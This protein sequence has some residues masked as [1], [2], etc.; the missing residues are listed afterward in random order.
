M[1]SDTTSLLP[2]RIN[3]FDDNTQ[4]ELAAFVDLTNE[5]RKCPNQQFL[6]EEGRKDGGSVNLSFDMSLAYGYKSSSQIS[7]RLTEGWV[8]ENMYCPRCGYD[9]L[10]QFDNNR[11]VADFYCPMCNEQFELKSKGGTKLERVLDGAYHT[12]IERI[13]TNENP[14]FFFLSY[15]PLDHVVT[16]MIVVPKH[17]F[18]PEI[19]E[20]RKP[21]ADTARRAG[22]TGCNILLN[23]V[24][25]QG[26]IHI[27]TNGVIEDMTSVIE[28]LS[29]SRALE[30][31]DMNSRGWLLDVL[32][33][34]NKMSTDEFS[35][36]Q[37]YQF[38]A[39]LASKHPDNHNIKAKIRQQL[40]MLRDRG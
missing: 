3:L 2:T 20:K 4:R 33:C 21:L 27:I 31:Q 12:M 28:N 34:V 5:I 22:W 36:G 10:A 11:P 16:N 23:S 18:V 32:H 15:A 17:F 25:K 40:Q 13:T 14:D 7:R 1:I 38:V 26:R 19:I 29:R 30:T 8:S 39:L 6:S 9:R 35:L 24:P 37:I